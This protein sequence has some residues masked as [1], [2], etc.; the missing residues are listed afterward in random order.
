M[1]KP[2]LFFQATIDGT[3]F[4]IDLEPAGGYCDNPMLKGRPQILL[5]DG[6][7]HDRITLVRLVHEMLHASNWSKSE[8][9]ITRTAKDI[10]R[11]LWRLYKPR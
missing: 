6:F 3:K 7:K 5:P 9:V 10:A 4:E 8:K 1:N 2:D 11:V